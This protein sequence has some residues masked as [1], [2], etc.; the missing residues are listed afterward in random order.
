[1]LTTFL[2]C[3]IRH[4]HLTEGVVG[5]VIGCGAA[6]ALLGV[7]LSARLRSQTLRLRLIVS[8]GAG[9]IA[10]IALLFVHDAGAVSII[11]AI[12]AFFVYGVGVAAYNVQA[13]SLRQA[14]TPPLGYGKVGAT[15][16]TFAYGSV[17]AGATLSGALV[18]FAGIYGTLVIATT[19]LIAGWIVMSGILWV[20]LRSTDIDPRTPTT[21]G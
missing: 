10:P 13:I 2:I 6:G 21:A 7:F 8:S 11:T 17:G 15:Y 5:V 16:R 18:T 4:S 14:V 12:T 9:A 1:M 20:S 3:A 19:T